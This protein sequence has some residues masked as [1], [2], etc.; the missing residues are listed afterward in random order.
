MKKKLL[1]GLAIAL[2]CACILAT[3]VFTVFDFKPR[4]GEKDSNALFCEYCAAGPE[5]ELRA[6]LERQSARTV[7]FTL[8]KTVDG[9]T[10]KRENY[11]PAGADEKLRELWDRFGVSAWGTLAEAEAAEGTVRSLRI[12]LGERELNWDSGK[13]LPPAGEGFPE[14][15]RALLSEYAKE[16]LW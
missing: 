13:A 16:E 11:V 10:E 8:E 15:V 1:T 12:T 4:Q 9:K 7:R 5:G 2:G 6:V 14:A 3:V